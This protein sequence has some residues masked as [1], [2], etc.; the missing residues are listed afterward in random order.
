MNAKTFKSE[1]DDLV[2]ELEDLITSMPDKGNTEE[3]SQR[4]VLMNRL[5]ELSYAV[6]GVEDE[7]FFDEDDG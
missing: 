4:V 3:D 1:V 2:S 7:D 5:N 6:N